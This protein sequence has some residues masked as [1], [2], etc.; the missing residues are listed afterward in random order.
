MV[1][2]LVVGFISTWF[3]IVLNSSA[4]STLQYLTPCPWSC[5][6]PTLGTHSDPACRTHNRGMKVEWHSNAPGIEGPHT[7]RKTRKEDQEGRPGRKTRKEALKS[8]A[9]MIICITGPARMVPAMCHHKLPTNSV[10]LLTLSKFQ[11]LKCVQ[12]VHSCP[13]MSCIHLVIALWAIW[14]LQNLGYIPFLPPLPWLQL[15]SE[16]LEALLCHGELVLERAALVL[17]RVLVKSN[18][19][20]PRDIQCWRVEETNSKHDFLYHT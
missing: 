17:L 11:W 14:C 5:W 10:T 7:T 2:H 15:F 9:D 4:L 8:Y 3:I 6:F 16:G 18:S 19:H 20:G 1:Y 12:L 13:T